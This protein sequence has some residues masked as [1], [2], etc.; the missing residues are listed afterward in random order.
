MPRQEGW[1]K[2][3]DLASLCFADGELE[4]RTGG[5][6]REKAERRIYVLSLQKKTSFINSTVQDAYV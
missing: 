2:A 6:W 1:E 3:A 5:G 4:K